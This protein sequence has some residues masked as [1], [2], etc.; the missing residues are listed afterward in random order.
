VGDGD[1]VVGDDSFAK[2][3]D[4]DVERSRTVRHF[5]CSR[6]EVLDLLTSTQQLSRFE[7]CEDLDNGVQKPGLVA[8]TARLG[9]VDGCGAN[10]ANVR[11][12]QLDNSRNQMRPT[13]PDVRTQRE[14]T[15]EHGP[16]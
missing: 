9:G 14:K 13:I 15:S 8:D 16:I 12:I 2:E 11:S 3:N 7:I 1:E 10:D 6:T 4:V 5:T